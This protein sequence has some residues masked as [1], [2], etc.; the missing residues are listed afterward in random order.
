VAARCS[1]PRFDSVSFRW[2]GRKHYG[3]GSSRERHDH[4]R[5]PSGNTVIA[6]FARDAE[7]RTGDQPQA[8]AKRRKRATVEDLKTGPR[9]RHSTTLPKPKR[10]WLS[11]SGGTPL[12]PLDDCL[13]A[14]QPTIPHLTRPALHRAF[15]GMAS[16]ARRTPRATSPSDSVSSA[17]EPRFTP[18]TARETIAGN[19]LRVH[20]SCS[21]IFS[22]EHKPRRP[23]CTRAMTKAIGA[24]KPPASKKRGAQPSWHGDH[25]NRDCED[26]HLHTFLF[27]AI[28]LVTLPSPGI[29]IF[30]CGVGLSLAIAPRRSPS[31]SG[32]RQ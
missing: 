17:T 25:S 16:L 8:V 29:V 10:Q 14:S 28:P 15:S 3:P 32:A 2:N 26:V 4:A 21:D 5:R 9:A 1:I 23:S 20:F 22:A 30:I 12:L 13:Y 6:G 27:P 11:R 31:T 24:I 7:P 18:S 19:K